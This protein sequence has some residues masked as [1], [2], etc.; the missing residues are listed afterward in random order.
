MK[1]HR[2]P[3]LL[4][5]LLTIPMLLKAQD[6]KV[7]LY[8]SRTAQ[9]D[10]GSDNIVRAISNILYG[11][12]KS[13]KVTLWDSPKKMMKITPTALAS[14]ERSSQT[15]FQETGMLFVYENWKLRKKEAE[16]EILGFSFTNRNGK[17]EDISYGY[18]DY[19]EVAELMR[20]SRIP[21]GISGYHDISP[22]QRLKY[23]EYRYNIVQYDGESVNSEASARIQAEVFT[24]RR[25]KADIAAPEKEKLIV[26]TIE[27]SDKLADDVSGKNSKLLFNAI[28]TFLTDNREIF[29][30]AGGDKAMSHV[31]KKN[32]TVSQ[33]EVTELWKKSTEGFSSRPSSLRIFVDGK[34]VGPFS[35][36]EVNSW[37]LPVGLVS[38]EDCIKDKKF[39][40]IISRVNDQEIKRYEAI[41]T[42]KALLNQEWSQL[43]LSG[44]VK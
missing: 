43:N 21:S 24:D 27:Y 13:G 35:I 19:A 20:V 38:M 6:K 14:I 17:G 16:I 11:S 31:G 44:G 12:I 5:M 33:V 29:F 39:H 41:R 28:E 22:E 42:Q 2:F 23:N 18:V 26:Y 10:S 37:Q 30:N 4:V 9:A 8:A 1:K 15:N 36:H 25:I 7:M 32:I 34:P 40:F 3:F